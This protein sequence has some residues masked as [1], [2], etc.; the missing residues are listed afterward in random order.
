MIIQ[1]LVNNRITKTDLNLWSVSAKLR[2]ANRLQSGYAQ[3]TSEGN[4]AVTSNSRQ[5]LLSNE[6]SHFV[7]GRPNAGFSEDLQTNAVDQLLDEGEVHMH[8]NPAALLE[9]FDE[10]FFPAPPPPP[11]TP[12]LLTSASA[13]AIADASINVS[14][15]EQ[16][17]MAQQHTRVPSWRHNLMRRLPA[18]AS[19]SHPSLSGELSDSAAAAHEAE[20]RPH[21]RLLQIL[22]RHRFGMLPVRV[23]KP[24]FGFHDQSTLSPTAAVPAHPAAVITSPRRS[25]S[26]TISSSLVQ[27]HSPLES[28]AHESTAGE[29]KRKQSET[30]S[31]SGDDASTAPERGISARANGTAV[32]TFFGAFLLFPL[33]SQATSEITAVRVCLGAEFHAC[34]SDES[35]SSSTATF[36]LASQAPLALDPIVYSSPSPAAGALV[37]GGMPP[38][39]VP[40]TSEQTQEH[41]HAAQ[42]EMKNASF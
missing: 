41:E 37:T 24:P 2:K 1:H 21:H 9:S 29:V 30:F 25:S 40:A 4:V 14:A 27:I 42:P 20:P 33:Q 6:S 38:T 12:A 8:A 5:P 13:A 23:Q 36:G 11:P 16:Q 10:N 7:D 19:L 3:Q 17:L 26:A 15:E 22:Q 39:V 31:D 18:S 32:P 34:T 35:E 28:N